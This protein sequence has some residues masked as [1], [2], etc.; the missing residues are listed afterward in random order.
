MAS[1]GFKITR[2]F[3]VPDAVLMPDFQSVEGRGKGIPFG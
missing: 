3:I 1:A 2:N